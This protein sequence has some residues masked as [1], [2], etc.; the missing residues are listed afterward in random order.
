MPAVPKKFQVQNYGYAHVT[1]IGEIV[2][3]HNMGGVAATLPVSL[4][5]VEW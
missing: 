1:L 4:G 3:A 2:V 5:F